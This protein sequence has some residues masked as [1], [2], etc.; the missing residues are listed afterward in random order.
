VLYEEE[1]KYLNL[2]IRNVLREEESEGMEE[3]QVENSNK[4]LDLD[5]KVKT[6]FVLFQISPSK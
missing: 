6:D 4:S 3:I 2:A 5:K 1:K